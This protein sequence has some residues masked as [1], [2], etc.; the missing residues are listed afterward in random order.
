MDAPWS[1]NKPSDAKFYNDLVA[2]G[3]SLDEILN[4]STTVERYVCALVCDNNNP[5]GSRAPLPS[6]EISVVVIVLDTFV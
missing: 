4:D 6:V 5:F 3:D 1:F 2:D